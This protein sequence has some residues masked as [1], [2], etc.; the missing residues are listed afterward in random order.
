MSSPLH[1]WPQVPELARRRFSF[2]P[3]ISGISCNEWTLHRIA[4]DEAI[5]RNA[6]THEEISIPRRFVGNVSRL[7]EPIRAVALTK[8]LEYSDG[9]L[10]PVNR[11]V[12]E[13]PPASGFP[14]VRAAHAATVVA[15]REEPE[16][17]P[18]WKHYLRISVALGCIACFVAVYVFREGRSSRVRRFSGRPSRLVPHPPGSGQL[19]PLERR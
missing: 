19:V 11:A 6:S 4:A 13:M 17:T 15:I 2:S 10:R 18:R 8:R 7:E 12:I 14:R 9:V 1:V 3:P 16:P 5:V